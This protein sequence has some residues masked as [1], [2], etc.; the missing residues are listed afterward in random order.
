[1]ISRALRLG[2][3]CSSGFLRSGLAP[4]GF[5]AADVVL[6]CRLGPGL[7]H[8]LS[9]FFQGFKGHANKHIVYAAVQ[10]AQDAMQAAQRRKDLVMRLMQQRAPKAEAVPKK[11][12]PGTPARTPASAATKP[13]PRKPDTLVCEPE[14]PVDENPGTQNP[15]S[16]RRHQKRSFSEARL[17]KLVKLGVDLWDAI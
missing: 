8:I 7:S 6:G 15:Q 5:L 3:V 14:D 4:S 11:L 16:P 17:H 10:V 2:R 13:P 12:E 9:P 1:M